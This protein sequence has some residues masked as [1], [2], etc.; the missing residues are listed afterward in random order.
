VLGCGGCI[1]VG[2]GV[3]NCCRLNIAMAS[4]AAVKLW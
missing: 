2:C 4:A 1:G 3:I